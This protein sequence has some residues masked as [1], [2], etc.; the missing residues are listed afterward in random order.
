MTYSSITTF[1]VSVVALAFS[2]LTNSLG[3]GRTSFYFLM[4]AGGI[5]S[6]LSLKF[7]KKS[8][9]SFLILENEFNG[10]DT[11]EFNS[12]DQLLFDHKK[13]DLVISIFSDSRDVEKNQFLTDLLKSLVEMESLFIAVKR[14]VLQSHRSNGSADTIEYQ[15]EGENYRIKLGFQNENRV[16]LAKNYFLEVLSKKLATSIK[17]S[18]VIKKL[19]EEYYRNSSL[20]FI[21]GFD[22]SNFEFITKCISGMHTRGLVVN[23]LISMVEFAMSHLEEL[24]ESAAISDYLNSNSSVFSGLDGICRVIYLDNFNDSSRI[25]SVVASL[26]SRNVSPIILVVNEDDEETNLTQIGSLYQIEKDLLPSNI[27]FFPLPPN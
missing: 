12:S 4:L 23:N 11:F 8:S 16:L 1:L 17:T 20:S 27:D 24:D 19:N 7:R 13:G 6:L 22:Y 14:V 3:G 25:P 2:V 15:W 18:D 26:K 10:V 9:G 21:S 5:G